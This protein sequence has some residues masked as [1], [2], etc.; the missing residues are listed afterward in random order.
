MAALSAAMVPS[1]FRMSLQSVEILLGDD[2]LLVESLVALVL[3]LGVG[4]L[5][6]VLLELGL[7]LGQATW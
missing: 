7:R 1:K 2:A 6:F 3:R 5:R 4:Q